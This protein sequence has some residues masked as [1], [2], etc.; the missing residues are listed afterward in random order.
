VFG[1]QSVEKALER[2]DEWERSASRRAEQAEALAQRTA[3]MSAI[4]R[5]RD[6]LVEVRVGPEGQLATVHL[7]ERTRQQPTAATERALIEAV[8]SAHRNLVSQFDAALSDTVGADSETG[9]TLTASL[10]RR[11]GLPVDQ[12]GAT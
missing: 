9:Q 11:L 7:D 10:R 5:S 4:G 2:I 3:K 12:P 6:G 1:D 8:Q